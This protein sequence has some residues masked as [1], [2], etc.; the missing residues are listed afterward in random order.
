MNIFES[1]AE[2]NEAL[3]SGNDL[4]ARNQLIRLLDYHESRSIAYSPLVN[5]LIRRTGLFPYIRSETA[6][7]EDRFI[8]EAFRVDVG[9]QLAILHKAQSTLLKMIIEGESIAVSAPTSFGKSFIVDAFIKI[10]NPKNVVIIVPTIA[11]TDETRRRIQKKFSREYKIITTSNVELSEKNILIFPQ[12]RANGYINLLETIDILIVD[13]FY[14]VSSAFDKERSP[15][16]HKAII[17]LGKKAKQRYYLAPNIKRISENQLTNDMKF[18]EL[19]DFNTVYLEK[20]EL[21]P[22]IQN[23][24]TKKSNALL[25][26][27]K[28][29]RSKSLV[30]AGVYT[31]IDKISTLLIEALEIKDNILLLNFADWLTKNYTANWELENLI[32]RGVGIHNGRLHRSLSQIQIKL[33]ELDDGLDTIVS[34]SSIIEGVNTSAENIIVWRN[35]KGRLK[36]DTFTY[37]NIIGRGGRMFKHFIGKIFLLEKPPEDETTQLEIPFPE[38]ILGDLDELKYAD[39]LT[40]DQVAAIIAYKDEMSDLLGAENYKNLLNG[41]IFQNSNAELIRK[42]AQDMKASPEEWAGLAYLNSNDPEKW[43]H[44]LYKILHIQPSGWETSYRNVITSVKVLSKNWVKS[45]PELLDELDD[46]N[47]SINEFFALERTISMKLSSLLAD[48]NEIQRVVLNNGVDI[49]PFVSKLSHAFLPPVVYQLEEY[50]LPRMISK[51][52]HDAGLVDFLDQT[53]TIHQAIS[54]LSEI[55]VNEMTSKDFWDPFDKFIIEY[56]YDGITPNEQDSSCVSI[57]ETAE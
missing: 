15:A 25:K 10:K 28:T 11:L 34:T 36:L 56:F 22:E 13:E 16:L 1:C 32:K 33:F 38:T 42:I 3:E 43:E 51:K 37:K 39:A 53:I 46:Y 2:V 30:Y 45:V 29:E 55:P 12:E 57:S 14:K 21:Y 6:L 19:L 27:L 49:S 35:R 40:S 52:I 18:I 26:I 47:I 24:E 8:C 31:Q 17:K 41:N 7:W 48:F 9:D 20:Y 4:H 5:H 50:G 54:T 44:I 23:D